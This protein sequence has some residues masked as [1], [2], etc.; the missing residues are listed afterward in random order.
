MDILGKLLGSQARVKIMRLFLLNKNLVFDNKEIAKRSRVKPEMLK[1]E[2][3]LLFSINF[4]KKRNTGWS[5][6]SSFKYIKEFEN[7]LI[8]ADTLDLNT[9]SQTFKNI[10]K[11]KLL[12]VSGVF[13]KNKDS[14]L[15]IFI[16]GDK[17]KKPKLEEA[18]SKMEAEIGTELAYALFD[19]KEFSYR[20]DMY[21]KLVRD[22][23][24]FPHKVVIQS[25][26][27]GNHVLK[28]R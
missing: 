2:I 26:E 12:I 1:K 22:V 13:I 21:D 17:I 10:G 5:F 16:V 27:F 3:N 20:L 6:N 11:V 25:K 23:L 18:I 14:R 4:L 28:R 19:T 8:S 7:L 24:D 9:I 15:D